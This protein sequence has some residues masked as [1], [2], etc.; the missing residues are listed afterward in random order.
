MKKIEKKTEQQIITVLTAVCEKSKT[1]YV[2][3]EWLTHTANYKN[4]PAS[5]NIV[6]VFSDETSEQ[7]A[8]TDALTQ[9]IVRVLAQANIRI[10]ARQVSIDNEV[11]CARDH[12][13][14]WAQRLSY[15]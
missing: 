15:H 13:G 5:L 14:N 3:F 10:H 1:E 12:N 8:D 9:H 6:C 4:F 2:G 11:R 7:Q